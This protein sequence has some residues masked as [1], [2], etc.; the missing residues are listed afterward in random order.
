[1]YKFKREIYVGD[2][3]YTMWFGLVSKSRDRHSNFT[4]FLLTESPDSEF[5]YAEKVK[6]G[7]A[8]KTEAQRYAVSYAKGLIRQMERERGEA[9][10]AREAEGKT[11]VDNDKDE[12]DE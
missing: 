5:S 2:R 3:S 7:F 6:S 11:Q 9:E 10:K 1:M 4:L 12:H 8:S